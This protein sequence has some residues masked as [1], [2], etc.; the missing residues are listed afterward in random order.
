MT[1]YLCFR[2]ILGFK[3]FSIQKPSTLSAAYQKYHESLSL[4]HPFALMFI[5]RKTKGLR[6]KIMTRPPLTS[7]L[8]CS[9]SRAALHY[10]VERAEACPMAESEV[11]IGFLG[12]VKLW[13]RIIFSGF[14]IG[15]MQVKSTAAQSRNVANRHKTRLHKRALPL[16]RRG[17]LLAHHM[18]RRYGR[19]RFLN[20]IYNRTLTPRVRW[21][22][23]AW[24][25]AW[26]PRMSFAGCD[27][28]PGRNSVCFATL[29][30]D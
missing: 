8:L 3:W 1:T 19:A 13:L 28:K 27:L 17:D 9:S 24:N 7:V 25:W 2:L 26:Q 18:M 22:F 21:C 10:G 16:A 12:R 5:T 30:P 4:G 23:T 20:W 14:G 6:R 15:Q 29:R 11:A